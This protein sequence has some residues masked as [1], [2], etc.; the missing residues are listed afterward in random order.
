ME[1]ISTDIAGGFINPTTFLLLIN[2]LIFQGRKFAKVGYYQKCSS[3]GH[4]LW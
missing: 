1:G 2:Y 3:L 4:K